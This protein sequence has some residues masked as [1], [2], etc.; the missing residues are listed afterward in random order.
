MSWTEKLRKIF[1][2]SSYLTVTESFFV[3]ME[4][5][6]QFEGCKE[7]GF[8]GRCK[9]CLSLFCEWHFNEHWA[10]CPFK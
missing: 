6:C 2:D 3:P 10:K 1:G 8:L 4:P 9:K 5:H 7:T